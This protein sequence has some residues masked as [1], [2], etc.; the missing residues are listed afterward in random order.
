M[1][2]KETRGR[3]PKSV[4]SGSERRG[5]GRPPAEDPKLVVSVR[6]ASTDAKKLAAVVAYRGQE[7]STVLR[8]LI[9]EEHARIRR[10]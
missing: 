1:R 7:R 5:P 4:D 6:L 2:P 9:A 3:R 10:R 8:D